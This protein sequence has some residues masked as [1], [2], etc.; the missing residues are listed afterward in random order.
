MDVNLWRWG[1]ALLCFCTLSSVC[2]LSITVL[3]AVAVILGWY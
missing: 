2:V 3:W 1:E